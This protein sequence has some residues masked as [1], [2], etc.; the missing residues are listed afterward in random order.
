MCAGA[1]GHGEQDASGWDVEQGE[2]S[3]EK[4]GWR[5]ETGCRRPRMGAGEV[6]LLREQAAPEA[7]DVLR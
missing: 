7:W 2:G 1:Q 4:G 6:P 3:G 5:E